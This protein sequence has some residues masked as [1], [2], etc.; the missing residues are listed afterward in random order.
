MPRKKKLI[1]GNFLFYFFELHPA[2]QF[3]ISAAVLSYLTHEICRMIGRAGRSPYKQGEGIMHQTINVSPRDKHIPTALWR[4]HF[5]VKSLDYPTNILIPQ[6]T[7][8]MLMVFPF[9]LGKSNSDLLSLYQYKTFIHLQTLVM[10]AAPTRALWNGKCR[11][12]K[13]QYRVVMKEG[14]AI[15]SSCHLSEFVWLSFADQFC[16][17]LFKKLFLENKTTPCFG[18]LLNFW[19][20]DC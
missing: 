14:S 3:F 2:L 17:M 11:V 9:H 18:I 8:P 16:K 7:T 10:V 4:C 13:R 12:P 6:R 5:V 15:H 1:S 19:R 20:N